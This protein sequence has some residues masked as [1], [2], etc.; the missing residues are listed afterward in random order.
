M[1]VGGSRSQKRVTR[2]EHVVQEERQNGDRERLTE[3]NGFS[4][5]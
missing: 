4:P 3:E 5:S 2:S 1:K